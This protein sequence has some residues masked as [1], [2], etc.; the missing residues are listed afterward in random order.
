MHLMQ[1]ICMPCKPYACCVTCRQ[2]HYLQHAI[3]DRSGHIVPVHMQKHCC[4]SSGYSPGPCLAN[5]QTQQV[6]LHLML[7]YLRCRSCSRNRLS[8]PT[9]ILALSAF[10][11]LLSRRCCSSAT[12][13]SSRSATACLKWSLLRKM[14]SLA[15]PTRPDGTDLQ[16]DA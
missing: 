7:S 4:Q 1:S 6:L 9:P 12:S 8:C 3:V 16:R 2:S 5:K 15:L 10:S 11:R 14:A 13:L